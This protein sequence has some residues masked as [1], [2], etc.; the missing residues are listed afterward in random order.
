[1][2]SAAQ[3]DYIKTIYML[4]NEN[5]TSVSTTMLSSHL[6]IKASSA[7][8]MLEKLHNQGYIRYAKYY[9]A[10]MT[11]I[12]TKAALRVVRRHRL[13]EVFLHQKLHF[14]GKEVHALAE[15]LEHVS[16]DLLINRLEGYLDHPVSDPH[17]API[18]SSSLAKNW[19]ILSSCPPNSRIQIVGI[20]PNNAL[21]LE[22]LRKQG[23]ALS[24]F[25]TVI[26]KEAYDNSMVVE[27]AGQTKAL[28]SKVAENVLITYV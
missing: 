13:W 11:Q 26:S 7:S 20:K 24:S 28:T 9:G 27:V 6:C 19:A 12:G 10:K 2:L 8:S 4:S 23:I 25:I 16:S 15:K 22:H 1:M 18:P 17:G 14:S 3:E 5:T 21:L